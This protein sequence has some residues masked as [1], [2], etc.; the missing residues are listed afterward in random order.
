MSAEIPAIRLRPRGLAFLPQELLTPE[1][2]RRFS[3]GKA[4]RNGDDLP[5][6]SVA[7]KLML[8]EYIADAEWSKELRLKRR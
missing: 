6:T 3:D 5:P 8:L 4:V 7:R 1:A 2:Q